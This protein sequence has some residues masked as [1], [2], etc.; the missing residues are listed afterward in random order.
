MFDVFI[1]YAWNDN[2]PD[3]NV[4]EGWVSTFRTGLMP[5]LARKRAKRDARF[6][7]DQGDLQRVGH[8]DDAIDS[9]VRNSAALVIVLSETY[10]GS[11][12]CARER[13]AF[14]DQHG[15]AAAKRIFV[16][17]LDEAEN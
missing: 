17:R 14:I 12:W 5:A 2:V 13:R 4:K 6:W 3:A 15:P 7:F 11:D 1:S 9:A 8:F 16:V 10:L